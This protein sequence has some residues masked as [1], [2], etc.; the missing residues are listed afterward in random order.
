MNQCQT[1]GLVGGQVLSYQRDGISSS[2]WCCP[3][4]VHNM[5]RE[6]DRLRERDRDFV[7][8]ANHEF[9]E[10]LISRGIWPMPPKG[11]ER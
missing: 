8:Q 2:V 10:S 6:L 5:K 3:N 7:Q 4:C 1:C 9:R 11:A